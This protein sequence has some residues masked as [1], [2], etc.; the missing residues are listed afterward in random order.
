M[1]HQLH[2][3]EA[4]L[5]QFPAGAARGLG[6][7]RSHGHLHQDGPAECTS[8]VQSCGALQVLRECPGPVTSD[9]RGTDGGRRASGKAIKSY[10]C[11]SHPSSTSMSFGHKRALVARSRVPTTSNRRTAA[12]GSLCKVHA[13]RYRP[14][15]FIVLK[16]IGMIQKANGNVKAY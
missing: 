8:L 16:E 7:L 12:A 15:D 1:L 5:P 4:G 3:P 6:L 10:F 11:V 13:S 2:Q 9:F 14:R